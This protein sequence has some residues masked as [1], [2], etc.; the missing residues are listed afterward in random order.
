MSSDECGGGDV[1]GSGGE[2][3]SGEDSGWKQCIPDW[4]HPIESSLSAWADGWTGN[5]VRNL[6]VGQLA[7]ASVSLKISYRTEATAVW[8]LRRHVNQV[9]EIQRQCYGIGSAENFVEMANGPDCIATVL[10]D[11]SDVP[12]KGGK[13]LLGDGEVLGYC[14]IQISADRRHLENGVATVTRILEVGVR[15]DLRREGV[16]TALVARVLKGS[17][18]RNKDTSVVTSVP[19]RFLDLLLFYHSLGFRADRRNPTEKD[20]DG[21]GLIQM[22]WHKPMDPDELINVLAFG[23]MPTTRNNL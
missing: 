12:V 18:L 2:S 14:M 20:N 5:E 4:R 19:E 16:G 17:L 7:E 1:H 3:G 13:R 11:Q 21:S 10:I 8:M 22:R 6:M 9:G 23:E 15:E